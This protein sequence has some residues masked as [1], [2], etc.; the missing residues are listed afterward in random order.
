[1]QLTQ[2]TIDGN[3]ITAYQPGEI[4]INGN[5]YQHS[6]IVNPTTIISPWSPTHIEQLDKTQLSIII[7]LQP[8]IILLA[9]GDQHCFPP[10]HL[11]T[12]IHNA[13]I[14]LEIMTNAAACRTY[15]VLASENRR[16]VMGIILP[17]SRS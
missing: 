16:V 5:H 15:N 9:V 11:L 4:S 3:Q 6:L 2:D 12:D 13:N 17:H 8:T 14:G 7:N 1:M 10:A